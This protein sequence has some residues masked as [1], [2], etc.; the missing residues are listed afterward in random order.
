MREAAPQG[1]L[2]RYLVVL[3]VNPDLSLCPSTDSRTT[4]VVWADE[5]YDA[6]SAAVIIAKQHRG[7][8]LRRV[9][10]IEEAPLPLGTAP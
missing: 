9:I 1:P 10:G 4:H 2:R 6:M 3:R 7:Q 5:P 8:L